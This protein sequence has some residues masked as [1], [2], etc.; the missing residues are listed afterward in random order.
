MPG[1]EG[2]TRFTVNSLGV[3][4][5]ELLPRESTYRILCIGGST[6]ECLYLDD[7][8][9]WPQL[10]MDTLNQHSDEQRMWVGNLGISGYSTVDH[11]KFLSEDTLWKE[12]DSLVFM[13]GANDLGGFLRFGITMR[14]PSDK[15]WDREQRLRSYEPVWRKSAVLETV[16]YIH[17]QWNIPR[18]LIE[19]EAGANYAVRRKM[20]QVA[21]LREDM[22]DLS[23]A[24]DQYGD[25]ITRMIALCKSAGVRP[26]FLT[27]PTV[28]S[29]HTPPEV[30]ALFWS[31]DDGHGK[32]FNVGPL[33]KGLDEYNQK[34]KQ[35]CIR[36]DVLCIDVTSINHRTDFFYDEYHFNEAGA[37]AVAEL[38]AKGLEQANGPFADQK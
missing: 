34:L 23:T 37:R 3:R 17:R 12:M 15:F 1:I 31:G 29:E 33:K 27:Q 21:S 10:L 4:G 11:L 5:P 19:D 36:E 26:V 18:L 6:T 30:T 32:Y 9:A 16:R 20:R 28:M 14:S 24:L 22:P 35:V 7:S 8:E 25:R 38:V 2:E 13:V